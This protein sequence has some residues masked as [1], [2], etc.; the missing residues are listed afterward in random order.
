[1]DRKQFV[2]TW[3]LVSLEAHYDNG[4][5]A[6]PLG[7]DALGVI[8]YDAQGHMTAQLMRRDRPRFTGNDQAR[9]TAEES[10][11]A[12]GGYIAY[13]GTYVLHEDGTVV[14]HVQGSLFPNWIGGEQLR[15]WEFCGERLILRT[16]PIT[17][18]GETGTTV[19][20]W[21]RVE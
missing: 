1:M 19:L 12:V 4:S 10:Q 8:T 14:H 6:Y 16:P 11:A 13:F 18:G 21:E 7:M 3:Q 17:F 20:V 5:T 2:G 9:G 15:F